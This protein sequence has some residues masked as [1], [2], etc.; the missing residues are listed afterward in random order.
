MFTKKTKQSLFF[1]T[2]IKIDIK[3]KTAEIVSINYF[4]F[5]TLNTDEVL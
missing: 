3:Y 4:I 1:T 5:V 2:K